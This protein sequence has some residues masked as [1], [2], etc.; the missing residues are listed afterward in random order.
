MKGIRE[1]DKTKKNQKIKEEDQTERKKKSLNLN[2]RKRR[3]KM[4]SQYNNIRR[5]KIMIVI[6][7]SQISHLIQVK[8]K[9][10]II[11]NQKILTIKK[12]KG[13]NKVIED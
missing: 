13:V 8:K 4:K 6:S 10:K 5:N 11:F 3:R 7:N 1:E 9:K 2:F 12:I